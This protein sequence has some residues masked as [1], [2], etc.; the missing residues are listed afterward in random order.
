MLKA[1]GGKQ[2]KVASPLSVLATHH[3]DHSL[4]TSVSILPQESIYEEFQRL[5]VDGNGRLNHSEVIDLVRLVMGGEPSDRHV[6]FLLTWIH[7]GDVDKVGLFT[8]NELLV[9]LRAVPVE[10]PG[11]RIEASTFEP[12]T[13]VGKNNNALFHLYESRLF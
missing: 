3:P 9:L 2:G 8:F 7:N 6:Q 11:G 1:D 5:D 12:P 13:T 4:H 10:Y